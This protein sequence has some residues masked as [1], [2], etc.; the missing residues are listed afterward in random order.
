MLTAAHPGETAIPRVVPPRFV[1]THQ[2]GGRQLLLII[3]N[4]SRDSRA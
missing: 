4:S 2:Q 1:D 3:I